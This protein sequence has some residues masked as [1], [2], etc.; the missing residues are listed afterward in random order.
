ME[1][2][3]IS[4]YMSEWSYCRTPSRRGELV[5]WDPP[6]GLAP[7]TIYSII[8]N[9]I[10]VYMASSLCLCA[11]LSYVIGNGLR[12]YPNPIGSHLILTLIK[13]ATSYFSNIHH[14]QVL[15][16]YKFWGNSINPYMELNK[17]KLCSSKSTLLRK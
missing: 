5:V 11:L 6:N 17:L 9:S 10:S 2:D 13:F 16:G 1:S 15:G 3:V 14:F 12:A 8:T 4:G 7:E